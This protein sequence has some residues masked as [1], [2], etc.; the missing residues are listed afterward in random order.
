ML[1]DA[2]LL[3]RLPFGFANALHSILAGFAIGLASYLAVLACLWLGTRNEH[4]RHLYRFWLR[5]FAVAF[6]AGVASAAVAAGEL[7]TGVSAYSAILP[8]VEPR[9]ALA[10]LSAR[11]TQIILGAYLTTAV[12][13]GAASAWRLRKDPEEP[14]S[15]LALKMAI[16]MFV[17]VAPLQLLVATTPAR[18]PSAMVAGLAIF[19]VG[20]W[21]A[22]HTWRGHLAQARGFLRA[23]MAMAPA[24]FVWLVAGGIVTGVRDMP[25]AASTAPLLA[26]GAAYAAIFAVGVFYVLRLMAVGPATAGGSRATTAHPA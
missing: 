23:C 9:L 10:A 8:T 14:E 1:F 11:L 3:S 26:F 12:V 7:A 20:L 25:R 13:V 6:G 2:L 21:G 19:G 24:G 15:C 22:L 17:I 4:F 16:G 5:I 18:L